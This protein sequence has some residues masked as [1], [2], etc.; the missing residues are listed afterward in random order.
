M[1]NIKLTCATLGFEYG[2]IANISEKTEPKVSISKEDAEVLIKEG[3]AVE[4]KPETVVEPD[5]SALKETAEADAEK[6]IA[7]A[8]VDA[9]K[10]IADAKAEAEKIIADVTKAPAS[11]KKGK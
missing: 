7:D 9:E 4:I 6:I 3:N 1:K 2:D 10:I 5:Y 8:K 11:K